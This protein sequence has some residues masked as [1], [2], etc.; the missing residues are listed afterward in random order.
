MNEGTPLGAFRFFD[1]SHTDLMRAPI[2]LFRI[3]RDAGADD[4]VPSR[5]ATFV[6]RDDVVQIQIL[7]LETLAA[8]LASVLIPFEDIVP[9]ELHLFAWHPIKEQEDDDTRDPDAERDGMHHII[10]RLADGKI[11]PTVKVMRRKILSIG[12]DDLGMSRT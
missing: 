1:E 5:C 9:C 7:S 6:S 2:S 10:I 12:I 8:I 3:T 11:V 4:I